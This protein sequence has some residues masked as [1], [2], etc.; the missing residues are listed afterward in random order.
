MG[1]LSKTA[2]MAIGTGF[3]AAAP[4]NPQGWGG[5]AI[6]FVAWILLRAAVMGFLRYVRV[7]AAFERFAETVYILA[8]LG[9]VVLW[10]LDP[11]LAWRQAAW[12]A[13]GGALFVGMIAMLRDPN[14]LGRFTYTAGIS[15][16]ALLLFT[17]FFGHQAGGARSWIGWGDVRLEPVEFSKILLAWFLAGYLADYRQLRAAATAVVTSSSPEAD[18]KGRPR[19]LRP[20]VL[21]TASAMIALAVQRDVGAALLMFSLLLLMMY[22]ATGRVLYLLGGGVAG[23]AALGLG[24]ILFEHVRLRLAVWLDPWQSVSG[25]GYQS[26][27][28]LYGLAYGGVW[29]RGLGEGF[30]GL[31]PAVTTDYVWVA[32]GEEL[33]LLGMIATL[34]LFALLVRTGFGIAARANS[35]FTALL[36]TGLVGVIAIQVTAIT[37]GVVRLLPLTG[38]TLPFVSY[39]GSSMTSNFILLGILGAI[40]RRAEESG[41]ERAKEREGQGK[42]AIPAEAQV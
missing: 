22:A 16:V 24:A 10:R 8:G 26:T 31:I 32:V 41:E 34:L 20:T 38:I 17:A 40:A 12:L 25:I 13:L 2:W 21:L 30:P 36:A 23:A 28:A 5:G 42:E 37:A 3:A 4:T 33:G 11:P 1:R 39:G 29:G 18:V 19:S 35:D 9:L 6:L 7:G 14:R 15:L 27:Q